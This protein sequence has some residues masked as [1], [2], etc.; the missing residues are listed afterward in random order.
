MNYEIIRREIERNH[1]TLKMLE[2]N[3]EEEKRREA[4]TSQA[5]RF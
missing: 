5:E 4:P 3:R 1:T 2:R